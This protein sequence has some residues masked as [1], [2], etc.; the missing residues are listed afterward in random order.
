MAAMGANMVLGWMLFNLDTAPAGQAL[1]SIGYGTLASGVLLV[2]LYALVQRSVPPG[3]VGRASGVFLAATYLPA[4]AS[5]YAFAA[6]QGA[7]GWGMAA[8][9]QMS[10]L[11]VIGIGALLAL[12]LRKLGKPAAVPAGA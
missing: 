7:Y 11:P 12:D 2:N 3:A 5:G 1:L 4:A 6:L 10:C 8:T 9:I